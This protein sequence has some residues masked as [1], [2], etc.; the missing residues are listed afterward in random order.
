[1]RESRMPGSVG[2]AGGQPPA[3][4][5]PLFCRENTRGKDARA[6]RK[7]AFAT[8]GHF[9]VLR[10]GQ[11]DHVGLGEGVRLRHS[12]FSGPIPVLPSPQTPLPGKE[13]LYIPPA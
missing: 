6:P 5:R 13:G 7:A 9:F 11:P 4:T 8:Q 2:A 1:M 12:P 3:A 10:G